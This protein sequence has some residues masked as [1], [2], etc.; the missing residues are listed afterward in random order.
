MESSYPYD[1][2][3]DS[4]YFPSRRHIV[5]EINWAPYVTSADS[6]LAYRFWS[7]AESE[8][9]E[10]IQKRGHSFLN[11]DQPEH[12]LAR[13]VYEHLTDP[14]VSLGPL[15]RTTDETLN[16]KRWT[17]DEVFGPDD[18]R[19]EDVCVNGKS[20]RDGSHWT[21]KQLQRE[22]AKHGLDTHGR[23]QD[24]VERLY[25]EERHRFLPRNNLSHWSIDW[26]EHDKQHAIR[27]TPTEGLNTLDMYTSAI[28]L[29]PYNPGYWLSRAYCYYRSF[30]DLA[31]GDAYRA[32]L[33]CEALCDPVAV[34]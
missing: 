19:G 16:E 11:D 20:L 31:L 8:L 6:G 29:S 5:F 27:F 3:S 12:A 22:L 2:D 25:D 34:N 4:P 23:R 28:K 1:D 13:A 30:F 17:Y 18:P 33:I 10:E 26:D 32:L 9:N 21:V 14:D 15:F 7:L 24:L